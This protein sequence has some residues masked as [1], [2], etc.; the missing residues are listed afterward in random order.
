M[1]P[2]TLLNLRSAVEIQ[3]I[4]IIISRSSGTKNKNM[5]STVVNFMAYAFHNCLVGA[6]V[7]PAKLNLIELLYA[8]VVFV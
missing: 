4:I 8:N 2:P 3:N 1:Q 6:G 5:S 7:K